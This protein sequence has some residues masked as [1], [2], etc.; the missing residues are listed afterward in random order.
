MLAQQRY[1]QKTLPDKTLV[2]K[3]MIFYQNIMILDAFDD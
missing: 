2:K 3:K 1:T